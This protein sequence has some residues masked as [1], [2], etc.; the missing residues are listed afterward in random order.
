MHGEELDAIL[1]AVTTKDRKTFTRM[2]NDFEEKYDVK[3]GAMDP[4]A[5]AV[6][7]QS[8]HMIV[9]NPQ[10]TPEHIES[11]LR[12]MRVI[13]NT[14]ACMQHHMSDVFDLC[15]RFLDHPDGNVR[16]AIVHLL[17]RYKF[18]ITLLFPERISTEDNPYE[19]LFLDQYLRMIDLET[20]FLSRHPAIA[21]AESRRKHL[22]MSTDTK[23]PILKTIR[24]AIELFGMGLLIEQL[25]EKYHV[26]LP[27]SFNM[28]LTDTFPSPAQTIME[29][30]A[31]LYQLKI[32]AKDIRPSIYRTIVV[33]DT[34]TFYDLHVYI[35]DVF[36]LSD[37]HLFSFEVPIPGSARPSFIE[38]PYGDPDPWDDTGR[39]ATDTKLKEVLNPLRKRCGYWYDFGDDWKFS[40]EL[41]K[42]LPTDVIDPKRLPHL[43]KAKGP[44]L[45]E[46]CRGNWGFADLLDMYD[47]LRAKKK[48][49]KEQRE[50]LEWRGFDSAEDFR[51]TMEELHDPQWEEFSFTNPQ[52][53]LREI[54]AA[55]ER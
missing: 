47:A 15:M 29:K 27:Y 18:G 13:L 55:N 17:D 6:I 30:P 35:Q 50:E 12:M 48:W 7:F 49:T 38:A 11:A 16:N 43:L 21:R 33:P 40:I 26:S 2:L 23:D 4:Q 14:K 46:D 39:Q 20:S 24:R 9:E 31:A 37:Y 52:R 54:N 53:R 44:N 22:P 19:R 32:Q 28:D 8:C 51:A 34:A 1:K 42:I 5:A 3:Y 45:L 10:S 41:Q 25:A 36:A